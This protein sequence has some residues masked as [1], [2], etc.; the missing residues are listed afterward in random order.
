MH[1]QWWE[2]YRGRDDDFVFVIEELAELKAPVGQV[3]V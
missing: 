2:A 1:R 3:A